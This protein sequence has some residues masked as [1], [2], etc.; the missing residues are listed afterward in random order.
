[1][2]WCARSTA[3]ECRFGSARSC[4]RIQ[5]QRGRVT[6]EATRHGQPC[7]V[8]AK[9]AIITLPVGV[10]QLAAHAPGAV[11]I[12]P[13]P[14]KQQALAGLAPGPVI[15]VVMHF[16]KPF[17]EE[18][19]DGRYRDGAFFRAP[20]APF[21]TFWSSV[22]LR[23]SL[24]NAWA[25]GPNAHAPLRQQRGGVGLRCARQSAIHVRQEGQSSLRCSNART[26]TTGRRILSRAARTATSSPVARRARK[27]LAAPVQNTL[28][29]AGEAADTQGESGTVAGALQ[30]GMRAARQ[31]LGD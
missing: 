22:P 9:R 27:A 12:L 3:T 25:G 11:R 15:K 21:R 31:V 17:W 19:D 16:R 23:G 29:F 10:L 26:C 6:I 7:S 20:G 18:I 14:R 13:D 4:T 28:F 30:S 8:Q 5:W 24:I 2:D 1:M